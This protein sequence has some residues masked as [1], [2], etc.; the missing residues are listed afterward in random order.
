VCVCVCV[1]EREREREKDYQFIEEYAK[2]YRLNSAYGISEKN[3]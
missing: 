2:L 3:V 1:C